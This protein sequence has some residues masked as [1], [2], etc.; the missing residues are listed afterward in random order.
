MRYFK[1]ILIGAIIGITA[2]A[3]FGGI[4]VF[5]DTS[6]TVS[7][8]IDSEDEEPFYTIT[9]DGEWN[10]P[11]EA[12][13]KEGYIFKGWTDGGLKL[14][15][16]G[17]A[18]TAGLT[19]DK[20]FFAVFEKEIKPIEKEPIFTETEKAFLLAGLALALALIAVF[21]Y[22]FVIKKKPKSK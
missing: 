18:Y 14:Y 19:G 9:P 13:Q 10:I 3:F 8:Y 6:Y 2:A 4:T 1:L 21:Y 16:S 12:P 7:F 11:A 20:S 15:A 17:E 22:I 5:A